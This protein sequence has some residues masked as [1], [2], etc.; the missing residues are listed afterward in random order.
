MVQWRETKVEGYAAMIGES[1]LLSVCVIPGLGSKAVSLRNRRTN[2]E[3]LWSSGKPLGNS[4]FGSAF[5]AGDES[6]W[7]EMFPGIDACSYPLAPWRGRQVPDH[8]EVW[9]RP[10]NHYSTATSLHCS[11][12]GVEFPYLLEKVYSFA[13]EET[14]RIDYCVTNRSESPFSF[15]WA[16]HPLLRIH[17]GMKLHVPGG[18]PEIEISYSA[19]ERLGRFGDKRAW[20]LVPSAGGTVDLSFTEPNSGRF[21]EKYYFTGRLDTGFA[22]LSDP[23][24]GEALTFSFPAEQV[25]YLAVWA[26]YG[27]F[28]GHYHLALEPATGRM[29][30]LSHAVRRDEAAVV[31]GGGVYRWY[32]EVNITQDG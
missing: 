18:L 19:G 26:N 10:W 1:E 14:L 32:L 21:A 13:S 23:A 15:L 31:P 16:A 2:R 9:S 5:A 27:G 24:T 11:V 29:D 30:D 25:P 6:G 12:E 22:G 17:D 3:W 4:G 8:G 28:G 20:P 7:D